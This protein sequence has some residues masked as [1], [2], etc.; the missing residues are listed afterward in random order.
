M[1]TASKERPG[2]EAQEKTQERQKW[3]RL[4][5]EHHWRGKSKGKGSSG[6]RIEKSTSQEK[7]GRVV[8]LGIKGK[9]CLGCLKGPPE[10]N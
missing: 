2:S 10:R 5:G 7:Q 8:P 1:E 6:T 3:E 4:T 9:K